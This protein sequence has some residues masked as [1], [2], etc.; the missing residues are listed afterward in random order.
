[1]MQS[2]QLP[3]VKN[4]K[5]RDHAAVRRR[6]NAGSPKAASAN[7]CRAERASYDVAACA[8]AA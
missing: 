5:D 4:S 1:M 3:F 2:H 6:D 7:P 8:P